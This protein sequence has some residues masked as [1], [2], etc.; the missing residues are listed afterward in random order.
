VKKILRI[1][2]TNIEKASAGVGVSLSELGNAVSDINPSK[3]VQEAYLT[4]DGKLDPKKIG[5]Q[6]TAEL[7]AQKRTPYSD[8]LESSGG[9][10]G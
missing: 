4:K 9:V 10:C 6:T 5:W 3:W 2:E 1:T 8:S 7:E